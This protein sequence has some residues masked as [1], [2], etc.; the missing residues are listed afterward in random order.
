MDRYD[1]AGVRYCLGNSGALK[2]KLG[3][4]QLDDVEAAERDITALTHRIVEYL[5]PPY[6]LQSLQAVHRTLFADLYDWAGELR[7][8]DI[9][10]GSTRFCTHG[11]IE[12]EAR[13]C[14]DAMAR[15]RW[16]QGLDPDAMCGK[17]AEHYCEPNMIH[18][19]R[20]GN[21]RVQR[22][23]FEQLALSAGHAL[24]W[25]DIDP[26]EWIEANLGGVRLDYRAMQAIFERII[27]R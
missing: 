18:P 24:D 26:G 5:P 7:N 19:F 25:S 4:T 13:R 3:I 8:V 16:L 1:D 20:E 2:N 14:F 17:L 21:G 12:A 27:A 6:S 10:K 15:D 11:R 23:L 9:S 22:I